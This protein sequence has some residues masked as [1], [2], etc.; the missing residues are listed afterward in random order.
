MKKQNYPENLVSIIVI[1]YNSSKFI[2]ETL[3][4]IKKQTY[5][6]IELIVCD[7]CSTDK[8][9]DIIESW[10]ENNKTRFFRFQII[11]SKINTGVPAN[12]NRGIKASNGDWIRLLAGD[13]LLKEDCIEYSVNAVIKDIEQIKVYRTSSTHFE[14]I[15]GEKKYFDNIQKKSIFYHPSITTKQQLILALRNINPSMTTF[16][17]NKEVYENVGGFDERFRLFEDRPFVIRLLEHNYKIFCDN[18]VTGYHRVHNESIFNSGKNNQVITDWTITS[19]IPVMKTYFLPK[20]SLIEVLLH[21][22]YFILA[23]F[24]HK[25]LNKK[26]QFNQLSYKFLKYPYV[27]MKNIIKK[28]IV[29]IVSIQLNFIRR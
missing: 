11:K 2:I 10:I 17:I 18:R 20:V 21:K 22:Y 14:V 23:R 1:T 8:T 7:D 12:L 19:Y 24:Y 9:I 16:F 27:L 13:D 5:K 4:S 3:E 6:S 29:L 15:D 25:N 28:I 26:T